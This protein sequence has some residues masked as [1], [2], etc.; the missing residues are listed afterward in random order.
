MIELTANVL[1]SG[2]GAQERGINNTGC[3]TCKVLNTSD[4][5][6]D[7][8]LA[9]AAIHCGLTKEMIENYDEYPSVDEMVEHLEKINL[10]YDPIKDKKYDWFK[11]GNKK[12][13]YDIK[14]YW[15]AA[16]L[17]HNLGDISKIDRLPYADLMTLSSPC[18]VEGTKVLTKEGYKNIEDIQI[19]D[20]V[21]THTNTYQKVIR[22]YINDTNT[23]CKFKTMVSNPIYVTPNHP[24]YI[25]KMERVI[26]RNQSYG[27]DEKYKRE[28]YKYVRK[29]SEPEWKELKDLDKTYYVG[30]PIN[31]N[32]SIPYWN[33]DERSKVKINPLLNKSA[34]WYMV[35]RFIGDGWIKGNYENPNT[36][37]GI[38][39]CGNDKKMSTLIPCVESLGLNYCVTTEKTVKKL[40]IIS[41]EL[42]KFFLQ[43]GKGAGNK[44]L[45]STIFNLPTDL[46][47]EFIHGVMDS[48]GHINK[49]GVYK[50]VSISNTLLYDL[51]QCIAKA[52]HRP[53]SIYHTK[54]KPTTIIDGRIV[55]QKDSYELAF[56]PNTNIQDHAFYENG[57]IWSPINSIEYL[58]ANTSVYNLEVENDNSYTVQNIIAHNCTDISLAGKMKGLDPDSGTRSSLLWQCLRL[59][60]N[61]K[62]DNVLP[63]YLLLEN[64]KNLVG[65]KFID[66]FKTFVEL[67]DE[68]GYNSYWKVLNG[69]VA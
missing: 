34:F 12:N 22:T 54:R 40:T 67:M 14:K 15:L 46:L 39:I 44:H 9:Y 25:R 37:I 53:F 51:G 7:A 61:A 57:Y 50:I 5:D 62:E 20:E 48:D 27:Y 41:N 68:I 26:D 6:K 43:F 66:D 13:K 69:R 33:D 52:Y 16:H 10:G 21:M 17:S 36:P 11:L 2:I 38:I 59:L 1:F 23:L 60:K 42:N 49:Q 18:F 4:I 31:T 64:V 24:F 35:G 29:F 45:T 8:T 32:S 63:K 30:T 65:K 19:G 3:F 55:N 58:D 56:K 28:R 47:K